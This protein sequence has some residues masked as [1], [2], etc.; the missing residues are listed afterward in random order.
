MGLEE[1]EKVRAPSGVKDGW[2]VAQQRNLSKEA[3]RKPCLPPAPSTED[4]GQSPP[5]RKPADRRLAP[6]RPCT[7]S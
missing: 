2:A 5:R 4:R 7:S 1:E 3:G 6:R